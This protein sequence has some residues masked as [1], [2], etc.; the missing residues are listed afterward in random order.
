MP[1]DFTV[2]TP[3]WTGL[4]HFAS[5]SCIQFFSPRSWYLFCDTC[6]QI[7]GWRFS[8]TTGLFLFFSQ[9]SIKL[10][11]TI[12]KFPFIIG[13]VHI[14]GFFKT[15]LAKISTHSTNWQFKT[16]KFIQRPIKSLYMTPGR[17]LMVPRNIPTSP[18]LK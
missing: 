2:S 9:F 12:E 17:T 8:V 4:A 13:Y 18:N 16:T 14:P 6:S 10:F 1:C 11:F 7:K 15:R 3:P 5:I